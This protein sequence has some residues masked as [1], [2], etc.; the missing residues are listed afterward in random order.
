MRMKRSQTFG[1]GSQVHYP[2]VRSVVRRVCRRMVAEGVHWSH[3]D[4]RDGPL[5]KP[6]RACDFLP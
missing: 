6:D 4:A 5:S 1:G 3:F 2:V